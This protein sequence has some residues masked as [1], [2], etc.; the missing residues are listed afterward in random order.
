MII[1]LFLT[2]CDPNED[3]YEAI[4]NDTKPYSE[5]FDLELTDADYTTIKK[6]A[7][8]EATTHE[9]STI[10]NDLD[11]FKSFST[12]R[13][14]A[15][16]IPP[17]IANNFI[18]LDSASAINV[19]YKLAVN[20][21]DSTHVEDIDYTEIFGVSDTCFSDSYRP[22]AYLLTVDTTTNYINYFKC[23][24]G[25][26][27]EDAVDTTFVFTFVDGAWVVPEHSYLFSAEDY[28]NV[29][30]TGS[31]L[32]F[33]ASKPAEHYLPTYLKSL[34]PYAFEKDEVLITYMYYNGSSTYPVTEGYRFNGTEWVNSIDVTSQ[35][36]H[37]GEKW[38]FDPTIN[39]T[40][41]KDDYQ[42]I[43][44]Y[45]ANHE[46]LYVYMSQYPNTEYYYGAS[47][48]YGNF[49]CRAYKRVENDPLGLLEG[50][51]DEQVVE[52]INNRLKE[53]IALFA[54]LK[55]PTQEPIENG[56]QVYYEISYKTYDG[57][58]HY[59]KTKVKCIDT[60]KFEYF[61]GPIEE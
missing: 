53:A 51:S 17:F 22:E 46:T 44:D 24:Y 42:L 5:K 61:S 21:Y 6:L 7:L 26:T 45:I 36:I 2:A 19:K 11:A 8:A 16:L 43:V 58:P 12:R 47:S 25:D 1:G 29:G 31:Y 41:S 4:K 15:K 50:L 35:F 18:A 39:Y 3:I 40:I 33:S 32:N 23:K 27:Y 57:A 56:T 9:D 60:G 52:E 14:P 30:I 20:D 54:E 55:F 59:Y 28:N 38:I 48:Y 34:Y 10:A 13:S 49:D 37:T